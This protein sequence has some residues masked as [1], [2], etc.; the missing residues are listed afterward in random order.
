MLKS[1]KLY[2]FKVSFI[3]ENITCGSLFLCVYSCSR[4]ILFYCE[5]RLITTTLTNQLYA[6]NRGGR[7]TR[8]PHTVFFPLRF[9]FIYYTF[10]CVSLYSQAIKLQTK[11]EQVGIL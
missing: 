10:E 7:E 8:A 11:Q 1:V 9:V 2:N 3:Q 5:A 4:P 6:N